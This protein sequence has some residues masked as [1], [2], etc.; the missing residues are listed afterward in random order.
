MSAVEFQLTEL[1]GTLK[2]LNKMD[3]YVAQELILLSELRRIADSAKKQ[4]E[5]ISLAALSKNMSSVLDTM[6]KV[7]KKDDIIL[8]FKAV[9]EGHLE[10]VKRLLTVNPELASTKGT[11][12][13]LSGRKFVD[14]TILQY[15]TWALDIE[16]AN[17][18]TKH[19]SEKD[20]KAQ[21]TVVSKQKDAFSEHTAHYS[22]LNLISKMEQYIQKS[23]SW[24]ELECETF[25]AK[26]V[27]V[28]QKQ[29]PAWLIYAWCGKS[30]HSN[31][32]DPDTLDCAPREYDAEPLDEKPLHFWFNFVK[33]SGAG[34]GS[35]WAF[36]R[37]EKPVYYLN[38]PWSPLL[39]SLTDLQYDM[40]RVQDL[41]SARREIQ[42][43]M[44]IGVPYKRA[45]NSSASRIGFFEG[46]FDSYPAYSNREISPVLTESERNPALALVP[47]PV[48]VSAQYLSPS[49]AV[50]SHYRDRDN[51]SPLSRKQEKEKPSGNCCENK[52]IVC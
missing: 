9:V 3:V 33:S 36:H 25:W 28:Q 15:A 12:L 4:H 26:E 46:D 47:A 22:A 32:P 5:D 40:E 23:P 43:T 42:Q 51:T 38:S 17:I 29:A 11:I 8:I 20:A 13:D 27:G 14:T 2:C 31:W 49:S 39:P 19:L 21:L 10:E 48:P 45:I 24:T 35:N 34:V 16:M 7:T 30:G 50:A 6:S 41:L 44:F 52:C 37:G 18:I 1:L